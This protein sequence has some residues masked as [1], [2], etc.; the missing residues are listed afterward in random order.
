MVRGWMLVA[1]AGLCLTSHAA[2]QNAGTSLSD[3][4]G[5]FRHSP[6]Q[7]PVQANA[8]QLQS[9]A[10]AANEPQWIHDSNVQPAAVD[11]PLKAT[12]RNSRSQRAAAQPAPAQKSGGLFSRF[13][14]PNLIPQSMR[15]NND[16]Q[17]E[18]PMPYG[19]EDVQD[20]RPAQRNAAAAP[21][22]RSRQTG[23]QA[24]RTGQSVNRNAQ[25]ASRSTQPA[26]QAAQR[27]G[28]PAVRKPQASQPQTVRSSPRPDA[29]RNELAEALS[30]LQDAEPAAEAAAPKT[31]ASPAAEESTPSYLR[32]AAKPKAAKAKPSQTSPR[33]ATKPARTTSS[34]PLDVR[35]ALL[36]KADPKD[37]VAPTPDDESAI[38]EEQ[39]PPASTTPEAEQQA[40]ATD[41]GLDGVDTTTTDGQEL[42]N[43]PAKA[44]PNVVP[45]T[46]PA[47]APATEPSTSPLRSSDWQSNADLRSSGDVLMSSRQPVIVSKVEGPQRIV[48]GRPAEYKITL[49][50]RG[51]DAARDV[52]ATVAVPNSAEVVDASASSGVVDRTAPAAEAGSAAINWQLYELAAG[53]S[54]TLTLQLVPRTGQPMQLG[55]QWAQAAVSSQTT[56]EVQEPKLLMEI[57]GPAEVLFGKAQRYSLTLSNPGT[58]SAEEVSID[59]TPPGGDQSSMV[60]HRVGT[61][62]PGQTKKIELELTAREAGD[63]KIQAAATAAGDLK[64]S[65]VK[66]VV[67]R[68]AELEIDWRGPDKNFAGA[69]ATYFFRVRN[70]GTAPADQVSVAV[71]LPK[72]AELIDASEGHAWD[73]AKTSIVWQ[74]GALGAGEQR[75]MQLRCRLSQPGINT[76]ALAARTAAGDLTN[77]KSVPVTVEA[78]A[79]L[80]LEV[81]D[82]KGIVPVG[83]TAMYEIHVSNRGSIAARGVNVVAMFSEGID[84]SHVEGGQYTIR[85]GRVSFRTI[86]NLAAGS[87]AVFRIHANALKEGTH[88]FRA[89]VVCDDLDTKL[90]AEETT[91]FFVEEQRWADASSAYEAAAAPATR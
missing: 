90:S 3:R 88:I 26:G 32:T 16:N 79:D 73:A 85:D 82:P 24:N 52:T 17:V 74:T 77:A 72:G 20:Q 80:K 66:T 15:G 22:A 35:D 78:L 71:E 61:L 50:N 10:Q 28:V 25:P 44:A 86:D 34:R 75:Y 48:V 6:D 59:L 5:L 89:E 31:P 7:A 83:D 40:P 1:A 41:D 49:E 46:T 39:S 30:G 33:T 42:G 55:V 4:L 63:L 36:G 51:D 38:S 65:A 47:T 12:N 2:A 84:P 69:V 14:M 54:Q 19:P 91:R 76:M 21:N 13:S 67:C 62:A 56:V 11:V 45:A 81:A 29:R 57:S 8:A 64:S 9:Q 23:A 58:G 37:E 70:P 18:P 53:A 87:E 27:G 43:I 68:K 60:H